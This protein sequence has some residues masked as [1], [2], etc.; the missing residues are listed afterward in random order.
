MTS[1][2]PR[3]VTTCAP[4]RPTASACVGDRRAGNP[5][6]PSPAR[7]GDP[8]SYLREERRPPPR[9]ER[10]AEMLVRER[11]RL[12]P[13]L[14]AVQEPHLHEERLVDFLESLPFLG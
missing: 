7:A 5:M 1:V 8:S 9:G 4:G 13:A 10:G 3:L 12:P 6:V 11:R 14:R 2:F